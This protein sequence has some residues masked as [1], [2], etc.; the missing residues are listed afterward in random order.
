MCRV[1]HQTRIISLAPS[2]A[3]LCPQPLFAPQTRP[4]MRVS[5]TH[6]QERRHQSKLPGSMQQNLMEDLRYL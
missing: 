5:E 2:D 4:Q 6:W 1:V 3:P